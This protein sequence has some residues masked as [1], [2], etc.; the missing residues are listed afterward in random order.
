MLKVSKKLE[1]AL[2]ALKFM[3][4]RPA[5]SLT[6]AREVADTLN[7]PFDPTSRVMQI[8]N[9]KGLLSSH[10]GKNGGY[11]LKLPLTEISYGELSEMIEGKLTNVKCIQGKCEMVSCCTILSPIEKLNLKTTEFYFNLKLGELMEKEVHA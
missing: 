6:S 11:F 10:Q 9:N 5:G 1:Y 8:M 3:S 7:I 2:M 4:E